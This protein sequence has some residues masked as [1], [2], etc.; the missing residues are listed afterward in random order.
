MERMGGRSD[1]RRTTDGPGTT[2]VMVKG[3]LLV[4]R[5]GGRPDTRRTLIE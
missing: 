2:D 1:T 3:G 4:E 5:M